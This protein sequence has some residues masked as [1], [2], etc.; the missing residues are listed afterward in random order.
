MDKS[1]EAFGETT[2]AHYGNPPDFPL[3]WR[4]P[5]HNGKTRLE[6]MAES[7]GLEIARY[8]DSGPDKFAISRRGYLLAEGL[9][10]NAAWQFFNG[11]A[12]G[13]GTFQEK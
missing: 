5:S 12:E 11:V 9:S 2:P 4:Q 3:W 1:L 6:I 13:R 10:A 7:V 8:S